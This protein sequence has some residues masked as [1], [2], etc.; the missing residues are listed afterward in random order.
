[1]IKGYLLFIFI[2]L[3]CWLVT[4]QEVI[5][6]KYFKNKYGEPSPDEKKAKA[7]ELTILEKDSTIR[8][9][10]HGISDNKLIKS[11]SY[12]NG[13]PVGKWLTTNGKELDY[14]FE[15]Y[16]YGNE[17]E[18]YI[19][20]DLIKK[21]T[22]PAV[23]ESFEPPVFPHDGSGFQAY[24]A[25]ELH[26]PEDCY[27]NGIQGKIMLQFIIDEKGKVSKLSV[28][29]GA[30][31]ILDKEAARVVR[32]SPEWIPAMNNGV[33]VSTCITLPIMFVLPQ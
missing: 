25:R 12:K 31:K 19:I 16:Y 7:Y 11:R 22:R 3:T 29:N 32:Q 10:M 30:D 5:E 13:I 17:Y 27:E 4:G 26:Y 6:K 9:E 2:G 33:P 18:D 23:L 21:S 1:M 14:D 28:L 20:Y 15:V 24:I 8:Y